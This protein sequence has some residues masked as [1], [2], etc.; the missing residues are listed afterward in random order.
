MK[1][2]NAIAGWILIYAALA[3]YLLAIG[4]GLWLSWN[5]GNT[6]PVIDEVI[7][8]TITSLNTVL[9]TNLGVVLGISV[10][11]PGSSLSRSFVPRSTLRGAG[12]VDNPLNNRERIQLG[13]LLVFILALIAC[14]VTWIVVVLVKKGHVAAFVG[15]A[16]KTF[17]A[18][19]I[20][21]IGFILGNQHSTAQNNQP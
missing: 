10:A 13:A 17:I 14:L 21:Y 9:L 18:I 5:S 11:M 3:C 15:V 6:A 4:Y 20:A 16:S 12:E 7:D 19:A 1:T 2:N 8:T